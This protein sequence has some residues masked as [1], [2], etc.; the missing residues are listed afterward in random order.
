MN[1]VESLLDVLALIGIILTGGFLVFFLGD[2]LL[3]VLDP[4]YGSIFKRRKKQ[5]QEEERPVVKEAEPT[6]VVEQTPATTEESVAANDVEED[7]ITLNDFDNLNEFDDAE[8]LK[9]QQM[10]EGA[11]AFSRDDAVAELKAEEERFKQEQLAQALARQE[12]KANEPAVEEENPEEEFDLDSIFVEDEDEDLANFNF[13]EEETPAETE[14]TPAEDEPVEEQTSETEQV[15]EEEA[16]AD[17]NQPD[18]ATLALMAEIERLK[19]EL[20]EARAAKP[21][22][23]EVKTVVNNM[24]E[25]ECLAKLDELK[26]RLKAN[27]K[28][29]KQAKKEYVPL[30]KIMKTLDNDKKKLRRKEAI[31]A[32]QKVVLYGVNNVVDI[33]QEK[34]QKLA[35]ELD[36]LDG[37]RLSVQHCEEVIKNNEERI[38]L[39]EKNYNILLQE[40]NNIKAD[41]ANMEELLKTFQ[42]VETT[43]E[44]NEETPVEETKPENN[45]GSENN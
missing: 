10:L 19:A 25:E 30:R 36:L 39:L 11:E 38:P 22:E 43:V 29:F 28:E 45:E 17:E 42:T 20:E 15:V 6:P 26:A 2:L 9:E 24:T 13:D 16:P 21:A 7:K 37:L 41:I 23:V 8:A 35:E 4:S 5:Q 1:L 32:K 3:S 31:V 33:D 12:A 14:E 27:E 40:N 44:T 34:A 18:E